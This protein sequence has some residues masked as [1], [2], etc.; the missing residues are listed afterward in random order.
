MEFPELYGKPSC[1][2]KVKHWIIKVI[3]NQDSTASIL[4]THGYIDHKM[5]TSSKHITCGKN[6]GKKNETT[7][8]QQAINEAKSLWKKQKE[9]G[10]SDS[11]SEL[12]ELS[13]TV[14]A[15]VLPM[16]AHDYNKRHKDIEPKY[17]IQP[18]LDG[19]RLIA[20]RRDNKIVFL[21]RTG[22]HINHLDHIARELSEHNVLSDDNMH[23][24]GEL[25]TSDL[26]F[27]E[28]SG[29]FRK[30]HLN[31]QDFARIKLMKFHVFDCFNTQDGSK[32]RFSERWLMINNL[33]LDRCKYITAVK[34]KFYDQSIINCD[35][36]IRMAHET[37]V[38]EGY[39]GVIIRNTDSVYKC[40]Y[41]SKDLQ[42]Y[43]E[44]ID[45]EY[46]I[47][48]GKEATGEDR[49]TVVFECKCN[50]STFMVRPRGSRAI[51]KHYLENIDGIIGKKL[52]VRY[53]NLSEQLVPRFP[54]GIAIRDYE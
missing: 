9:A 49:G 38:Q 25:Y 24:D 17:C 13:S 10:Y 33:K 19:V 20:T 31:E 46:T 30:T 44:F 27:D 34:T 2:S 42:K 37:F 12:C 35:E 48:G 45:A 21:S 52:T 29:L 6:I 50:N 15:Q 4:R 28:L 54:V 22:K 39:E 18:K 16:L 26:P 32:L 7:C 53:Q 40:G 11:R 41:R 8:L 1:G 43:K 47:V 36:S 23:I 3:E 5:T 14:D 51:R